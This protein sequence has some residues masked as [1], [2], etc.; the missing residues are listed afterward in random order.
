MYNYNE[1]SKYDQYLIDLNENVNESKTISEKNKVGHSLIGDSIYDAIFEVGRQY[2]FPEEKIK[3]DIYVAIHGGHNYKNFYLVKLYQQD[4][5]NDEFRKKKI[6]NPKS[7]RKV[8]KKP[9]KKCRCK[10]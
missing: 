6:T 9:I 5:E 2:G 7:K 1:V 4:H 10:S 3:S 8:V